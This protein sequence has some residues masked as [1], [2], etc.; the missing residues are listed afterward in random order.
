[1]DKQ[2]QQQNKE[3]WQQSIGKYLVLVQIWRNTE[4]AY[5]VNNKEKLK[6][7]GNKSQP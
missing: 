6:S 2:Y 1:M 3:T 7:K 5:W 4:S